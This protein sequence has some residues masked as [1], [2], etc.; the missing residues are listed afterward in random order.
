[1]R[2][3]FTLLLAALVVIALFA[4]PAIAL[5]DDGSPPGDTLFGLTAI[6]AVVLVGVTIAAAD[7]FKDMLKAKTKAQ[8][9]LIVLLVGAAIVAVNHYLGLESWVMQLLAVPMTAAGYYKL[10]GARAAT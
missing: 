3:L 7:F 1:M 8:N 5:A 4:L 9:L 10:F 2:K 6:S